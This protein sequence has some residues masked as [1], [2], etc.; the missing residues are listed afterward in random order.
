[1]YNDEDNDILSTEKHPIVG[2]VLCEIFLLGFPLFWFWFFK[3]LFNV[4]ESHDDLSFYTAMFLGFL[5]GLL[6]QLIC[7]LKGMLNESRFISKTRKRKLKENLKISFR[8]A[9]KC[10]FMD[11][12]LNGIGYIIYSLTIYIT[13]IFTLYSLKEIFLI[14]VQ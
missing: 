4:Y 8:F 9:M 1:M 2:F 5:I 10:Y 6:F 13:F 14:L 7:I 11:V 3:K 12:R